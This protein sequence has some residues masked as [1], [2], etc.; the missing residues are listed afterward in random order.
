MQT[1]AVD[2]SGGERERSSQTT[3]ARG[4]T[5]K[6]SLNALASILDYGAR[7]AVA[8][9]INPFLV[10]GLGAFGFGTWEVLRRLVGQ[11]TPASGRPTQALKWTIAREQSSADWEG[12]RRHL[13]AALAVALVFLAP[14]L[15]AGAAVAW[16]APAWLHA[17]P[18]WVGQIRVATAVLLGS[19]VLVSLTAFPRAVLDGENLGYKRMGLSAAVV[20]AGGGLVML[21]IKLETGLVG[22]AAATAFTSLV[23]GL[24]FFTV[25]RRYVPWFGLA[26]PSSGA[27][28]R[29][30][31]LSWWFLVWNVTMRLMN[32]SDVLILGMA[33]SPV[34]VTTY[35]LSR[36][37]PEAGG[38]LVV[39]A[40]VGASPGLG[41]LLGSGDLGK[42]R[43]IR[44]EIMMLVWLTSTVIGACVLL[45]NRSFLGLWVDESYYAGQVPMLLIIL[46]AAQLALIRSDAGLIDLSLEIRPKVLLGV[47]SLGVSVLLAVLLVGFRGGGIVGLCAGFLAGRSIMS[48]AYPRRVGRLLEVPLAS[49]LKA[50]RRPAVTTLLILALCFALGPR[51]SLGS[52]FSL[53][54]A[55]I[56]SCGLV[57]S[58]ALLGGLRPDQRGRLI[59]RSRIA[60]SELL[61]RRR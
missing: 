47:L 28:R 46:L 16:F 52:W 27:V 9:V 23:S 37:V 4:L 15:V 51:V 34:L 8:F 7:M 17:P 35:T 20:L 41:G 50:A 36:Y 40:I 10:R 33:D 31:G 54:G 22:V 53:I 42:V 18:E 49:Q 32:G 5:R 13:G 11:L 58:A 21:A 48:A 29:F 43:R 61:A 24:V 44:E 25:V 57:A 59:A 3:R 12:K 1:A 14:T 30:L 38:Y 60:T 45:L 55:G 19:V 39:L 6:A 26:R 2:S 56:V